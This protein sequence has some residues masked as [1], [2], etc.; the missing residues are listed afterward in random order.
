MILTVE[1][2]ILPNPTF[3]ELTDL[4]LLNLQKSPNVDVKPP[5]L[6]AAF[7]KKNVHMRAIAL[8]TNKIFST[9]QKSA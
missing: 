1:L 2:T 3:A 5:P 7:L 8:L 4:G 9:G 6:L